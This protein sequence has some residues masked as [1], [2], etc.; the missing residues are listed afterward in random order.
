MSKTLPKEQGLI[1]TI[2]AGFAF[3]IG[4]LIS[5]FIHIDEAWLVV[6]WRSLFAGIFMLAVMLYKFGTIGTIK[7]IHALKLPGLIVAIATG[8]SISFFVVALSYTTVA[9]VVLISASSPVL[10]ALLLYMVF[11]EKT[12]VSTW[13]A[14]I[15]VLIGVGVMVFASK[16]QGQN[17][18]H[19]LQNKAWVGT[20][21]AFAISAC[22]AIMAVT[23]NKN[24]HITMLAATMLGAFMAAMAALLIL[25]L[26]GVNII[27]YGENLFWLWAFGMINLGLGMSLFI[28][29]A[30]V[31][32]AAIT[33]L[34]ILIEPVFA[35]IW[36]WLVHNEV[37]SSPTLIGGIIILIA[38]T[39][40]IFYQIKFEKKN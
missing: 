32:S 24:N 2:A 14:I 8:C 15:A 26:K 1:I 23:T 10:A 18:N 33:T 11:G 35:P 36:V 9:E 19:Q 3:S 4:G 40:H 13:W 27:V 29:G 25:I 37:P 6:F 17:I 30:K 12:A 20:A 7:K 34:I 21:L 16:E 22:F 31:L 28:S 38:I 5:R 39:S